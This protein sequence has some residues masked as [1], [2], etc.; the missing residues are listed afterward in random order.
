MMSNP[1][2][3]AILMVLDI[4]GSMSDTVYL[5]KGGRC[6]RH[7]IMQRALHNMLEEQARK[8][9]GYLTVD[10]GH[11]DNYAN[12]IETDADPMTVD[13]ALHARGGTQ[14]YRGTLELVREFEARIK[15]M[16]EN[17][18]P[19]HVVVIIMTDGDSSMDVTQGKAA[20]KNQ[21]LIAEGWDFAFLAAHHGA[22]DKTIHGLGIPASSG[23]E[24]AFTEDGV[25]SM[26]KQLGSFVS[27]SRS[28]E[29]GHF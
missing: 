29:R 25:N 11:F 9:A 1:N 16:P 17:E 15:S 20:A 28:G 27:M 2:Y 3:T 10:V 26:V 6:E 22:L 13:L 18:Q 7:E 8:L 4:S 19:G 23:V 5:D 21:Q 14:V 12:M 24:E